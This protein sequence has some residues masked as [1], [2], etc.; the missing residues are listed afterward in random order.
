MNFQQINNSFC[1]LV[2]LVRNNAYPTYPEFT[3]FISR[4]KT[5]NLFPLTSSQDKYSLA[6]SGFIYSGKKDIVECFCCGIILH[7]WEKEDNPW[8]EHS[9][10]N[11]KCVFVLLS[12]GNQFVE[13]VVKKYGSIELATAIYKVKIVHLCTSYYNFILIHCRT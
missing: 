7:R 3:T 8:I 10:W 4:L 9:R 13:N 2:S 6:E 11:P 12:K 1:S 5:F